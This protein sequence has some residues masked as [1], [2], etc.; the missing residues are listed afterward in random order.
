ME[1]GVSKYSP[2]VL[3]YVGDAVIELLARESLVLNEE[4]Q[5]SVMNEKCRRFVTAKSQ[6]EASIKAEELFD[7]EEATIF[8]RGKNTRIVHPPRSSDIKDYHRATGL[9]AV[10]GYLYLSGKH[11]RAKWLFENIYGVRV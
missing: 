9:E 8:R 2:L 7:E 10:F 11:D 5:L 1:K 6:S 4:A 3:A